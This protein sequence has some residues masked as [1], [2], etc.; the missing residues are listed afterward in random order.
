MLW[1][2]VK[3]M[4]RKRKR[5]ITTVTC[6]LTRQAL[7]STIF[8]ASFRPSLLNELFLLELMITSWPLHRYSQ[9]E[10]RARRNQAFANK[11]SH[12]TH[13]KVILLVHGLFPPLVPCQSNRL[14]PYPLK[15]VPNLLVCFLVPLMLTS[16]RLHNHHRHLCPES[17]SPSSAYSLYLNHSF[18]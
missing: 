17:T 5:Y 10:S 8:I 2:I 14:S 18:P 7:R 15:P 3:M 16:F 1:S 4:P 9:P 12:K 13:F 11:S 6:S